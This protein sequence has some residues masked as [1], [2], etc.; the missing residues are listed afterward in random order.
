[1]KS[2]IYIHQQQIFGHLQDLYWYI[3]EVA[4]IILAA[5][6]YKSCSFSAKTTLGDW[7]L[8]HF[9]GLDEDKSHLVESSVQENKMSKG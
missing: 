9:Q 8:E 3:C 7:Y 5:Q 2:D 4:G 1:M 6:K